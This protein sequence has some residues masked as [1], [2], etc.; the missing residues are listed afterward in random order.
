MLTFATLCNSQRRLP[1][2]LPAYCAQAKVCPTLYGDG[3]SCIPGC[4]PAGRQCHEIGQT[5]ECSFPPTHLRAAL[6]VCNQQ[7]TNKRRCAVTQPR[8]TPPPSGATHFAHN[9]ALIHHHRR[10]KTGTATRGAT[11]RW[12]STCDQS[13]RAS[14]ASGPSH[15]APIAAPPLSTRERTYRTATSVERV[16]L[17]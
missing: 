12:S 2:R 9:A 5:W 1:L 14:Q 11:T 17:Y 4:A 13:R 16:T 10:S 15:R 3:D 6:Q 7:Q 8:R